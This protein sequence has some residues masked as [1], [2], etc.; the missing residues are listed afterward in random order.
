MALL[1]DRRGLGVALCDDEPPQVRAILA[2]HLLPRRLAL[3]FAE[4]HLALGLGRRQENPPSI[5]L[6]L[7]VIEVRPALRLHADRRA[8]VD[9]GAGRSLRP[10]VAPP[11]EK[12]GLPLLERALERLVAC[13]IHVVGDFLAVVDAHTRSQLNFALLPVPNILSA[14]VSP[15]ALG[16]MKIQFCHA[17]SRPN[18]RVSIV[19]VTPKRRFA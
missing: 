8:Q 5:I 2:R 10:H 6:H 7:H 13:E 9:I 14:P 4:I 16:R 17:D 18:T 15:T 19:S 1:L 11:V 12:S 3:V